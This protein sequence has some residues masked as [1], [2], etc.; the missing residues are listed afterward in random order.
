MW[1]W[2]VGYYSDTSSRTDSAL[3]VCVRQVFHKPTR[4]HTGW[5]ALEE[6]RRVA[7]G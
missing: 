1:Q 2:V 7:D 4:T 5:E 3:A 6:R